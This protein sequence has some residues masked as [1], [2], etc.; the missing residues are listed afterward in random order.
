[1]RATESYVESPPP[2]TVWTMPPPVMR[3][4]MPRISRPVPN[5]FLHFVR[6]FKGSG[7]EDEIHAL[8]HLALCYEQQSKI[9]RGGVAL[10]SRGRGLRQDG[11]GLGV[12]TSTGAARA[13]GP[14]VL[15]EEWRGFEERRVVC[16]GDAAVC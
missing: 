15:R 16:E 11:S 14:N 3:L 9:R 13:T 1:M 8:A 4:F 12:G 2:K 5:I 7:G 10:R 6:A